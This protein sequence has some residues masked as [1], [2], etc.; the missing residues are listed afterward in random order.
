MSENKNNAV[1]FAKFVKSILDTILKLDANSTSSYMA[2][3]PVPPK[4]INKFK[5]KNA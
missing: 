1:C 5:K 4:Q 3:Q 2:Y